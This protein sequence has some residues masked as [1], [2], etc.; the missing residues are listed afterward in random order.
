[1]EL[2]E[3][4]LVGLVIAR[5]VI[6]LINSK[7][8]ITEEQLTALVASNLVKFSVTIATIKAEMAKYGV[9]VK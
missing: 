6:Q 4:T 2:F 5:E 7:K 1:M 3:A 8:D 9:E